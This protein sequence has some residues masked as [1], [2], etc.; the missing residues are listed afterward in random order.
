MSTLVP[1]YYWRFENPPV[2]ISG[3]WRFSD[4]IASKG[5]DIQTPSYY[6]NRYTNSYERLS[7]GPMGNYLSFTGQLVNPGP[8]KYEV[9]AKVDSVQ[10]TN[11]FALEFI[12]KPGRRF[13]STTFVLFTNPYLRI[14]FLAGPPWNSSR[15]LF[16]IQYG[17][18]DE[19]IYLDGVNR[20]SANYLFDGNWHHIVFRIQTNSSGNFIFEVFIDGESPSQLKYIGTGRGFSVNT[21]GTMSLFSDNNSNYSYYNSFDGFIDEVA[22]YD[23]LLQDDL[24]LQHYRNFTAGTSYQT[25]TSISVPTP[26]S[27]VGNYNSFEYIPGNNLIVATYNGRTLSAST[28][29]NTPSIQPLRQIQTFRLPRFKSGHT[30]PE[31]FNWNDISYLAGQARMMATSTPPLYTGSITQAQYLSNIANINYELAFKWNYLLSLGYYQLTDPQTQIFS[32]GTN[33]RTDTYRGVLAKQANDYPNKGVQLITL[34]AQLIPDE[35]VTSKYLAPNNYLRNASGA[36]LNYN[37]NVT[38]DVNCKTW[39]PASNPLN[40]IADGQRVQSFLNTWA[41]ALPNRPANKKITFIN[42]NGELNLGCGFIEDNGI[43]QDPTANAERI[44]L[45]LT[46]QQYAASGYTRMSIR[47]WRD[48]IITGQFS[49][50]KYSEYAIQGYPPPVMRDYQYGRYLNLPMNNQYY[51]TID[52]YPRFPANWRYWMSVDHG[53][54]WVI[55]CRSNEIPLG[56]NLFSPF[57]CA[58]WYQ[59]E[60]EGMRPAQYLGLLKLMGIMGA[61]FY[62]NAYFNGVNGFAPQLPEN[63]CWQVAMGPYSQAITSRYEDVLR[64]GFV[65]VGDMPLGYGGEK[66]ENNFPV[67]YQFYCGNPT[68]VVMVRKHN[69]LNKWVIA[70][71]VQDVTNL[72]NNPEINQVTSIN[73]NGEELTFVSRK[74]GSVYI[75]DKTDTSNTIFYQVDGWHEWKHPVYWTKDFQIETALYETASSGVKIKTY[76]DSSL[77]GGN[78]SAFTSYI[79]FSASSQTATYQFEPRPEDSGITQYYLYIY[80]RSVPETNNGGV[81]ITLQNSGGTIQTNSIQCVANTNWTWYSYDSITTNRI[82]Y[83]SLNAQ[84]YTIT[85][86]SINSNIEISQIYVSSSSTI[87][88]TS[89]TTCASVTPLPTTSVTPTNTPTKQQHRLLLQPIQ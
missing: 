64:N 55:I 19:Y 12:F 80:A 6:S 62:Y 44:S 68:K 2:A 50:T 58:G 73:L 88:N 49:Q 67:G 14:K 4:T 57:I 42:E 86:T 30:L 16:W 18:I 10:R 74:Q 54:G 51:S 38:T 27:V 7:N 3:Y 61:E 45:G 78:Y 59:A 87:Y 28:G 32:G 70:T 53:L 63:W 75:Y 77:T 41:S 17:S 79:S 35:V 26:Q 9:M 52:F 5:L 37:G 22:Y 66:R 25:T 46:P 60:E 47:S 24:I 82:I 83:S 40:F 84:L 43:L 29:V 39:S 76:R 1:T 56:D 11:N 71:T 21:Q 36:F 69:T 65:L 23:N 85:L 89:L 31:I 34:R 72:N 20:R 13:W 48:Y 33:V 15:P 81:N 8:I